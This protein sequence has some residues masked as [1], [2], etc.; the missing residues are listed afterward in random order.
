MLVMSLAIKRRTLWLVAVLS[1]DLSK[2]DIQ[3][4]I[5]VLGR[6]SPSSLRCGLLSACTA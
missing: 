5:V 1:K 3:D 2:L 6:I 4:G